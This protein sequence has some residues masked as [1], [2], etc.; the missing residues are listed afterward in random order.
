MFVLWRTKRMQLR[1][2]RHTTSVPSVER[3]IRY[4][5]IYIYTVLHLECWKCARMRFHCANGLLVLH[6]SG[7]TVLF[8]VFEPRPLWGERIGFVFFVAMTTLATTPRRDITSK[9]KEKES[10]THL[11]AGYDRVDSSL[12][13][14]VHVLGDVVKPV[15]GVSGAGGA[16]HGV[17]A[18]D[19]DLGGRELKFCFAVFQN[20]SRG[21]TPNIITV[22]FVLCTSDSHEFDSDV[23]SDSHSAMRLRQAAI[24]SPSYQRLLV[25]FV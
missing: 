22:T 2:H 24:S 14:R 19:G 25:Q 3:A 1:N 12:L 21:W 5:Y 15:R 4:I 16:V 11:D 17:H 18:H 10:K 9:N 23:R 13:W 20:K 6:I 7:N 8:S